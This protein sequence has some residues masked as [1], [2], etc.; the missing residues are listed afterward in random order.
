MNEA[1]GV[2][3]KEVDI[4]Y[5]HFLARFVEPENMADRYPRTVGRLLFGGTLNVFEMVGKD[6]HDVKLHGFFSPLLADCCA[7]FTAF[8]RGAIN[9]VEDRHARKVGKPDGSTVQIKV[10]ERRIDDDF[11]VSGERVHGNKSGRCQHKGY[12]ENERY[13]A[14]RSTSSSEMSS[15]L[16]S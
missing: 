1:H 14:M 10:I 13:I 11:K 8:L 3:D 7:T 9:G 6:I 16:R 4:S 2:A 12:C 15:C 5:V